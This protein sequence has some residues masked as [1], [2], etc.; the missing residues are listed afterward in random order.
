MSNKTHFQMLDDTAGDLIPDTI[1]LMPRIAAQLNER[2]SLMQI[3]RARPVLVMV[4]AILAF[5]VLSG[6]AYAIGK[7]MGYIP[8]I[9]MIDQSTQLRVLAEPISVTRDGITLTVEQVVLSADKTVLVYKIEGIPED[10][11]APWEENT[12]NSYS[13]VVTTEGTPESRPVPTEVTPEFSSCVPDVY[14]LLP[15]GSTL[16]MHTGEGTGWMTGFENRSVY[17]PLPAGVNEVTLIMPCVEGA[18]VGRLPENWEVPLRFES[19][20]S[21]MIVLPVVEVTASTSHASQSAMKL[22]QVIETNHG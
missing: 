17:G 7:V 5:L 19:A 1:D 18:L 22:E 14:F 15:D 8:G 13:V 11:Y 6:V 20:P 16:H 3:F 2:K 12:S 4:I 21:D 10:A 9:G